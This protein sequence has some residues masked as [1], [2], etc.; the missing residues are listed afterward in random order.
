MR[1]ASSGLEKTP[2]TGWPG[3]EAE[4]PAWTTVAAALGVALAL[5]LVAFASIGSFARYTADDYCWAGVLRTSGFLNAQVQWYTEYSPRYAFT[6]LVN[7]V[8]LAGPGIVPALPATAIVVWCATLT[9]TFVQFGVRLGRL[10][11]KTSAVLLAELMVVGSLQTAPDLAQSLYWQTGMLT[12]VLPLVLATFLIGWI[13]RAIDAR[14]LSP[15]TLGV[16][17]LVTFVAGGLSET[18]LIPQNVA[19]TL[20]LLV[21]TVLGSP[22]SGRYVVSAHLAAALAGGVV[23]LVVIVVAP[24]TALRV[25][26]S[27]ADLWL[28][29]SASIATAAFQVIRLARFFPLIAL[30]CLGLPAVLGGGPACIERRW[31]AIVTAVVLITIPFCYFPSFFAQNG[32]PPARSLIV[33]GTIFIGYLVFAGYALRGFLERVPAS[34]RIVATLALALVPVGI[35]I[36]S[37]TEQVSAAQTAA[38]TWDAQ[39][40]RIRASR[41]AGLTDVTVPRP[42]P[43]LGEN[44]VTSNP[45]DWFNVCVARYYGLRSIA[46]STSTSAATSTS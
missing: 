37:V 5:P 15:W 34:A 38:A 3:R 20:A 19:L 31:F 21:P 29:A 17:W 24:A 40:Q 39:D 14:S 45:N 30:L 13:R 16:S 6:F 35:A 9:W 36:T 33:P 10:P 1:R 42:P 8:E 18:Y 46:T 28:T 11:T 12:Y 7:L 41:D 27:P 2:F 26:G 32:N 4:K 22:R 23:A 44:F 25:G 43:F